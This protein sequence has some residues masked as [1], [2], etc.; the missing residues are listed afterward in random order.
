MFYTFRQNNSGGRFARDNNVDMYVVV[1]GTDVSDV[2][3]R[4]EN[5][6]I[7]FDGCANFQDCECCGDRWYKPW[8][9]TELDAVPSIYSEPIDEMRD[10]RTKGCN[11]VIHFA[12]GTRKYAIA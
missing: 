6:G 5:I 2:I 11:T 3:E 8:D 4:A 1:E 10:T 9:G 7:Y 12:D